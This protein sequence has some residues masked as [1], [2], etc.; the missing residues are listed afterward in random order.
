MYDAG[1]ISLRRFKI[2]LEIKN[3]IEYNTELL[4]SVKFRMPCAE[5]PNKTSKIGIFASFPNIPKYLL[6]IL[7][8]GSLNFTLEFTKKVK[9][10]GRVTSVAALGFFSGGGG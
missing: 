2:P 5:V 6:F 1:R 4:A 9:F 3:K 10:T 8:L 7:Q